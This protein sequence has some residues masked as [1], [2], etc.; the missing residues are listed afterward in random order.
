[1]GTRIAVDR[2]AA[3]II[4]MSYATLVLASTTPT[5]RSLSTAPPQATDCRAN[6]RGRCAGA[7]RGFNIGPNG[8]DDFATISRPDHK[9]VHAL[10]IDHAQSPR[11]RDQL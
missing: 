5:T 2:G 6:D 8:S 9:P 3:A 1:M 4:Q 7:D 10:E 11:L